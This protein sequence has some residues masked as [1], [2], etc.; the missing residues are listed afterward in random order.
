MENIIKDID[1]ISPDEAQACDFKTTEEENTGK[2]KKLYIESYGC[3]MNFSDSEIVA[4]IMKE[5]GFDTTADFQQADVIFL[6]TCSIREKAEQTVRKRLSQFN[7][8]KKQKPELTIGVLGCMAERLKDKLLE[9]EKIVDVVVG[10]DAY[11]DLPNLVASAEEGTKGVNTFLSREETYADISPVRLNSNGVS[12]FIS[13]MRGCDNMC[14]FCVVPFTRG[15]ERS[16]D[17]HSIVQE[18]RELFEKGYREVTLLGQNVDSYKWSPEENNK[19]RLNRKEEE[20]TTVI[21]FA[22]LLEMVAQIDPLLRIRFS[23]SHPKDIT[24]QVLYTIKKYDNICKYIHLPVQSGNSRVLELMNRTY[25]REWYLDRVRAIREILGEECGI[26]SDMIAGFCTETEEE[27]RDTLSLMEIVKYD[28]S[29]M[30]YYSERPGTLAAK[31]YADDIPLEI[32]KRRLAEIIEKQAQLSLERNKLDLG[33]VY[34]ILIE[35]TSKRSE[36]QLKGK[37][38]ANKVV[39]IPNDGTLKKGDYVH[40]RIKDC[41]AATLFGEPIA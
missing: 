4:S 23:T 19:A 25:D 33:K 2:T 3:Q 30:F 17:P 35:G 15:R 8:I 26:S 39:I 24:D 38:S 31:K 34:E 40:V 21:N 9:E 28:F 20:V 6:N 10:P 12:G 41:S 18:A 22:H 5:N 37:N 14:S 13:I 7:A 29:Y 1:I 16:R 32:K 27:H 36:D 11:R